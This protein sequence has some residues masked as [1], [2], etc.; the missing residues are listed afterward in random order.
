MVIGR[1]LVFKGHVFWPAGGWGDFHSM[2]DDPEEAR[3]AATLGENE[4]VHVLDVETMEIVYQAT[5]DTVE[6]FEVN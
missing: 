4:W 3:A 1:Y 6:K 5:L 2:W